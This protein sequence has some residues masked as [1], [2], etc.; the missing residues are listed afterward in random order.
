MNI[1]TFTGNLGRDAETRLAGGSTVCNFSVGVKAG[2]GDKATT[3]WAN[4]ALWGKQAEGSLPSYLKKG[5]Q[6]AISGEIS[7]REYEKEGQTRK[8][9]EV[10]VSSIDLIGKRDE[11]TTSQPAQPVQ[12][13]R[14]SPTP[15]PS[16]TIDD[17]DIPF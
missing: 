1:W 2:Y 13:V 17:D 15:M 9:L 4:C 12:P 11:A 10:R 14:K 8:V 5:Q 7:E 16:G 3:V 6:V